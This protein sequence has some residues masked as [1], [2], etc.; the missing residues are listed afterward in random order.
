MEKKV[1]LQPTPAKII[2]SEMIDLW[3]EGINKY[4]NF[5][6]IRS[7]LRAFRT[8]CH[9][10]DDGENGFTIVSSSVF[11]KVMLFVL[12]EMDGVLRELLKFP[13]S[14]G[15]KETVLELTTTT[16]WKKYGPLIRL[17]LGNTL[18]VLNQMTDEQMIAFTLKRVKDSAVFLAAFPVL[19]RKYLKVYVPF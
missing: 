7:L 2:T 6:A 15:K 19:L 16:L 5:S 3:C 14:G 8:A 9:H 18:H 13:I 10:G 4:E 1:K 17:Y 12:N 11:N